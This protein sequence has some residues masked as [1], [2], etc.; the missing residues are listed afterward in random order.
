[1]TASLA[2]TSPPSDKDCGPSNYGFYGPVDWAKPNFSH[3]QGGFCHRFHLYSVLSPYCRLHPARARECH[4]EWLQSSQPPRSFFTG[5]VM[6]KPWS[7]RRLRKKRQIRQL[8]LPGQMV[9]SGTMYFQDMNTSLSVNEAGSSKVP[10]LSHGTSRQV[11]QMSSAR[12][13]IGLDPLPSK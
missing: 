9:P 7:A 10:K 2:C 5:V 6:S 11:S 8:E 13:S 1:M 4:P 12:S 3:T